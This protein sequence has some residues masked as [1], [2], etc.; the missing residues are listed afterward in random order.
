LHVAV[1]CIISDLGC[2]DDEYLTE[3]LP[4]I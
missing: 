4:G 1:A 2:T 3:C